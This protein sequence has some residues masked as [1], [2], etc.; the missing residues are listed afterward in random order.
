MLCLDA[1]SVHGQQSLRSFWFRQPPAGAANAIKVEVK[2]NTPASAGIF[3]ASQPLD[4]A[5]T[6]LTPAPGARLLDS[7]V[8]RLG[9]SLQ[10]F[11]SLLRNEACP[12]RNPPS[13]TWSNLATI[14]LSGLVPIAFSGCPRG[15]RVA[16][17]LGAR[18]TQRLTSQLRLALEPECLENR[19]APPEK[20]PGMERTRSETLKLFVVSDIWR[21]SS[22]LSSIRSIRSCNLLARVRR[23]ISGLMPLATRRVELLE[24]TRLTE[25][26]VAALLNS[27]SDRD[28]SRV[29]SSERN[30][31]SCSVCVWTQPRL[32]SRSEEPV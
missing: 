32:Q 8:Q 10:R 18:S 17:R 31:A 22:L 20:I 23:A 2:K 15:P 11:S 16:V 7:I 29:E 9:F 28:C 27:S 6:V 26:M 25:A 24:R 30:L 4:G 19:T 13:R 12:F 5:G 3:L 1:T 14:V 21:R